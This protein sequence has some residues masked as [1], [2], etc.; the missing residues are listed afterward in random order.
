M[1]GALEELILNAVT[2]K[3]KSV[4]PKVM[5][6]TEGASKIRT[7]GININGDIKELKSLSK[8]YKPLRYLKVLQIS[9]IDLPKQRIQKIFKSK[10]LKGI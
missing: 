6:I 7:L 8:I 5:A 1:M 9:G 2:V 4:I 3:S 10:Y